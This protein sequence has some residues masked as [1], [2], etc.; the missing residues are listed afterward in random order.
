MAVA[1]PQGGSK[2]VINC[3]YYFLHFAGKVMTSRASHCD[4]RDV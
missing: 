1:I 2:L 4:A 3:Q